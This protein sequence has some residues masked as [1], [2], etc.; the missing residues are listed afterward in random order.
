[1]TSAI[2]EKA[3]QNEQQNQTTITNM[4]YIQNLCPFFN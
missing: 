3:I 2:F 1:M 4:K